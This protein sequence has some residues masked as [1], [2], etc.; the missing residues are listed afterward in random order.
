MEPRA[1]AADGCGVPGPESEN[2]IVW[3]T[4]LLA[5]LPSLTRFAGFEEFHRNG[6][7]QVHCEYLPCVNNFKS[8]VW[9]E[10]TPG[11]KSLRVVIAP[12]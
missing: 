2:L 5:S 3:P 1:K 7:D 9:D 8:F 6:S 11:T 12:K 4:V 10:S